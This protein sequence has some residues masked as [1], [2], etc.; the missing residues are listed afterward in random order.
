M[1]GRCVE[2]II[3]TATEAEKQKA[4]PINN[5]SD[6]VWVHLPTFYFWTGLI[7]GSV[8][9]TFAV[10]SIFL[11]EGIFRFIGVAWFGLVALVCGLLAWASKIWNIIVYRDKGY[12]YYTTVFN[13]VYKCYFS[14]CVVTGKNR[15]RII[16]KYER[17]NKT[18]IVDPHAI[19]VEILLSHLNKKI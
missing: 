5:K 19:N 17:K 1:H 16:I 3:S 2:R 10:L 11:G 4:F 8:Q 18:F 13:R 14:E 15:N 9:F 7:C 12:F 6:T